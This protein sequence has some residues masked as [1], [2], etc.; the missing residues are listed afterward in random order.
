MTSSL[1]FPCELSPQRRKAGIWAGKDKLPASNAKF[2]QLNTQKPYAI[3]QGRY[4][5]DDYIEALRDNYTLATAT[6]RLLLE[7]HFPSASEIIFISLISFFNSSL[8]TITI[9]IINS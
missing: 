6:L 4:L 8:Q 7:V 9:I 5:Q 3:T 1:C 2:T